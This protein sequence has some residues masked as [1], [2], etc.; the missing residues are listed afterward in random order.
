MIALFVLLAQSR[1]LSGSL[2]SHAER[3]TVNDTKTNRV[4]SLIFFMLIDLY[5]DELLRYESKRAAQRTVIPH[6]KDAILV[7]LGN[8][9]IMKL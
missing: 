3:V 2:L 9:L 7:N 6:S 4:Y 5:S 8:Y 1:V